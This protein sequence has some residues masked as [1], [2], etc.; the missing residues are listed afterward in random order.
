MH[1]RNHY[2]A[3]SKIDFGGYAG[4]QVAGR[5]PRDCCM[6]VLPITLEMLSFREANQRKIIKHG[7]KS[8]FVYRCLKLLE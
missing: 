5:G 6:C 2:S 3:P 4:N 1:Y 7:S 8:V